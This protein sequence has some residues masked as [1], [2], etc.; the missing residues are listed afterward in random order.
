MAIEN[1]EKQETYLF[2][3]KES[4]EKIK[5]FIRLLWGSDIPRQYATISTLS[6]LRHVPDEKTNIEDYLTEVKETDISS[7]LIIAQEF[8]SGKLIRFLNANDSGKLAEFCCSYNLQ[9]AKETEKLFKKVFGYS[10]DDYPHK[11]VN[12]PQ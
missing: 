8:S 11:E 6:R 4:P 5:Q 10:F 12:T 2:L 1:R 9:N 3:N 7:R